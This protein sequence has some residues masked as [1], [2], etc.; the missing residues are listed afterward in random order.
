MNKISPTACLFVSIAVDK[1]MNESDL[2]SPGLNCPILFINIHNNFFL[3][4][5]DTIYT[6]YCY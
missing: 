2:L 5:P 3:L 6:I 4:V 1:K